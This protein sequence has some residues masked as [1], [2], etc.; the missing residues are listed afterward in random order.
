MSQLA[1][2][3]VFVSR[4]CPTLCDPVD[5]SPP[6]FSVHGILQARILEWV[7]MPFSRCCSLPGLI[8]FLIHT[9]SQIPGPHHLRFSFSG[10]QEYVEV[11]TQKALGSYRSDDSSTKGMNHLLCALMSGGAQLHFKDKMTGLQ[12]VLVCFSWPWTFP[13]LVFFGNGMWDVFELR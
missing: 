5:C 10:E 3:C 7:A 12:W 6:G 8:T 1:A 13:Q 9:Y 2:F 11:G 4:S